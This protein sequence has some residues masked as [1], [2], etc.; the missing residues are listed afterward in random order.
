MYRVILG[1]NAMFEEEMRKS[2]YKR[3]HKT[4]IIINVVYYD[5]F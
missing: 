5:K 3:Y 2:F 4:K 1:L